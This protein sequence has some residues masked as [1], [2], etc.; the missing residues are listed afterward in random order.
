M[1]ASSTRSFFLLP[2]WMWH[3]WLESQQPSYVYKTGSPVLRWAL[4]LLLLFMICKR[5]VNLWLICAIIT[6]GLHYKQLIECQ[7]DIGWLLLCHLLP[8]VIHLMS[9]SFSNGKDNSCP[10]LQTLLLTSKAQERK[11]LHPSI[12]IAWLLCLSGGCLLP[13]IWPDNCC[14]TKRC[15]C[16]PTSML[17]QGC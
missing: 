15:A 16:L 17:A 10:A 4:N 3:W 13:I 7:M 6:L 11:V 2:I 5:K 1:C 8:W 12:K 9:L 14:W